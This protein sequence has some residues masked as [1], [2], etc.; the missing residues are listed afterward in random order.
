MDHFQKR[1]RY[2][3]IKASFLKGLCVASTLTALVFL[4]VLLG[5]IIRD[6]L[7][8]LDWSFIVNFPSRIPANAGIQSALMGSIWLIVMTC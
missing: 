1:L 6:G 2:R 7:H 3:K 5:T 8:F 4:V